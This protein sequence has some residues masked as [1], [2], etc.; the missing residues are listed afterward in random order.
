MAELNDSMRE[1]LSGCHYATLATFNEGGSIHLT[2]VWYLLENDRFYVS[3]GSSA[4]KAKNILERHEVSIMVDS[5]RAQGDERWVSAVGTAEIISGEKS[6]EINSKILS[7]YLTQAAL[8]DPRVGPGFAA[9]GEATICVTPNSWQSWEFSSVDNNFF[10]GI[11]GQDP[12]K[13]FKAVD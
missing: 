8:D 3:T 10:G 4:R 7:R 2:P 9:A 13:W 1:F 11:L 5:R 6:K 12:D